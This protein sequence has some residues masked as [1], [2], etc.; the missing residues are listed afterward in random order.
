M[1]EN[2]TVITANETGEG[3][4]AP[5]PPRSLIKKWHLNN[6]ADPVDHDR[7]MAT[8]EANIKAMAERLPT[9]IDN[10]LKNSR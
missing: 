10:L 8:I 4:F 5:L 2:D 9:H 7:V 3:T 6:D 1:G